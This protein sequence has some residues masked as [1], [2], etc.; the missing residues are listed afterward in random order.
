V[1]EELVKMEVL[2]EMGCLELQ[3]LAVAVEELDKALILE[4]L[5]VMVVQDLLS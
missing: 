4:F 2:L 1:A 5:V 3:I